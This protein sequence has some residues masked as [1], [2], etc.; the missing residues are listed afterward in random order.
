MKK[1]IIIQQQQQQQHQ[2][3]DLNKK[4]SKGSKN[5]NPHRNIFL[6]KLSFFLTG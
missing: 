5:R 4:K 2:Q 1:K 6:Y 3:K